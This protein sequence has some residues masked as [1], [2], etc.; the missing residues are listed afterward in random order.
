MKKSIIS[1]VVIMTIISLSA[2]GSEGSKESEA[3][4]DVKKETKAVAQNQVENVPNANVGASELKKNTAPKVVETPVDLDLTKL[5]TTMA[6]SQV[7][8][9]IWYPEKYVGKI[10]KMNGSVSIWTDN[11]TGRTYYTCLFSDA[12]ACCVRG[13]EF[14]LKND[15]KLASSYKEGDNIVVMGEFSTYKEGGKQWCELKNSNVL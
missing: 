13:I 12:T 3:K 10:V 6:Y 4:N 11:K 1:L 7:N 2:C 8:D 15:Q 14:R 9:M 5:S